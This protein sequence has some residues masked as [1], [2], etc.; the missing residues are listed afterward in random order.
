ML[1]IL[2]ALKT[3]EPQLEIR[4]VCDKKFAPQAQT[5]LARTNLSI[6]LKTVAAGKLRRYHGVP[7]W[8]QLLDIPTL[9]LNIRDIFLI[10]VGIF[11]SIWQLLRFRP[12]VVFTKG[13]F[14][15]LPVG[16]AA[17]LL[18]KPLI[19]HDS[20][21]HPGLTNRVLAKW[22]DYI[23]TGAPIEN[24]PYDKARTSYTGIPVA[25]SFQRITAE[26]QAVLKQ[27]V[28]RDANRPLVVVTGGGLGAERINL[29]M[30]TIA[31]ELLHQGLEVIHIA[32]AAHGDTVM[33][34]VG[35]A[36]PQ[37]LRPYY[38]VKAF[39]APD[40]MATFLK[41]ADLVISRSGAT[42][43]A[44]LAALGKAT[45][46]I[47][48][49]YLTGGHQLK[50]A[51]IF[52]DASAAIVVQEQTLV[53]QPQLFAERIVAAA[54]YVPQREI[55]EKNILSLAKPQAAADVAALIEKATKKAKG[56]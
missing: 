35:Q 48:S 45:I 56:E 47:P 25:Q 27:Q 12:T 19:I 38:Q 18:R 40:E 6:T 49:P 50:A 29:A 9:V 36:L 3:Q 10:G 24:Y 42:T 8:K 16:I 11:Q 41:A 34:S 43:M 33:E 20:D 4:F 21:P 17:H 26:E 53:T 15:C 22:A 30:L 44:E 14:V 13:G 23:A 55:L 2:E 39:V 37:D 54:T 46:L 32:G 7:L 51:K 52:G 31:P 5:I 28:M 1:A